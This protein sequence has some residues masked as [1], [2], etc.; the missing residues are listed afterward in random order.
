MLS[1]CFL[2]AVWLKD[3]HIQGDGWQTHVST[4]YQEEPEFRRVCFLI[5][6]HGPGYHHGIM[7]SYIEQPFE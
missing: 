3:G 4:L 5:V 2:E 7:D 1:R 6:W